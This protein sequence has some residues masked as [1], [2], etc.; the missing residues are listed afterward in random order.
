MFSLFTWG[1]AS[2]VN[3]RGDGIWHAIH[4]IHK[5]DAKISIDVTKKSCK[6]CENTSG[7]SA[8]TEIRLLRQVSFLD[9]EKLPNTEKEM[10]EFY[11][12]T[13]H[14]GIPDKG[15]KSPIDVWCNL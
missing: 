13:E 12:N 14:S 6:L 7:D 5:P 2:T 1:C 15:V 4:G 8:S 11:A 9:L 10:A 3:L